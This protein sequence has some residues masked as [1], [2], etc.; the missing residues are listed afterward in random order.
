MATSAVVITSDPDLVSTWDYDKL[1]TKCSEFNTIL[2]GIVKDALSITT[3]YDR[4][5]IKIITVDETN[6]N[7]FKVTFEYHHVADDTA[8]STITLI[9][10]SPNKVDVIA[11]T[12]KY[13]AYADVK[14]DFDYML[15][16][17]KDLNPTT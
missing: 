1:Y 13:T 15:T 6:N 3:G 4:K 5:M 10:S 16:K 8:G 17:V 7:K 12:Q 11:S 9:L 2:L 14:T